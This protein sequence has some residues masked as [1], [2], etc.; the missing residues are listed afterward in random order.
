MEEIEVKQ[1]TDSS[2]NVNEESIQSET[3]FDVKKKDK[4]VKILPI[5]KDNSE[6]SIKVPF[7]KLP[8]NERD[9]E[10]T[11]PKIVYPA[12]LYSS[13][14]FNWL[15]DVIK[16][17]TEENPVKLS[18]LDEI[19]P[20]VQSKHFY[21]EIMIKWYG[22]YNKRV[23]AKST[24]YPLFLTLLCTNTR[25]IIISLIL[26]FIRFLSEFFFVLSFKEIITR[27]N[28]NKKRHKTILSSFT[29]LELIFFM[30]INKCVGLISSRQIVFYVENLGKFTTVQLNCLIYDKLLKL[31]SY[32]KGTFTEGQIINLIQTDSEKF[33]IFIA[34]SPEVIILPF[35][36]IY[37]V[38]ILFSFFH[39]SFVIGF[40]L[41]IIMIY[42]FFVFGS[43]EKKYQRQMMKAADLRMNLTTQVF[44]ICLG[45][46][47]FTKN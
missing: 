11:S 22:T 41:L 23:K 20:E 33:G 17:R 36:L 38:Y 1:N 21:N 40:I 35:K 32:N 16:R 7:K 12:N 34:T 15:Y 9:E 18:N 5:L 43:K 6:K 29:L 44:I 47:I 13:L 30:L 26:F 42:L 45:K 19:S 25:R 2:I 27:F 31:A 37:S 8:K 14:S 24:G 46:C 10:K 3:E 4:K 39:E 28:Q